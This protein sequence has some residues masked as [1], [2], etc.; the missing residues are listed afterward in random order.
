MAGICRRTNALPRDICKEYKD[1]FKNA[2]VD[3]NEAED[4]RM[5]PKLVV[6]TNAVARDIFDV[7]NYSGFC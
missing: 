1:I 6:K 2:S 5:G 3:V 7:P 4:E